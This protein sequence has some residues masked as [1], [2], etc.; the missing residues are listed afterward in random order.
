M[1]RKLIISFVF[2]MFSTVVQ[3]GPMAG[4]QITFAWDEHT[5]ERVEGFRLYYGKISRF[6]QSVLEA[7]SDRFALFC[8]KDQIPELYTAEQYDSCVET[9]VN[10][11]P[12][13]KACD[14]DYY[15][16]DTVVPII[17][18]EKTEYTLKNLPDG[19]YY[20]TLTAYFGKLESKFSN[21]LKHEIDAK[22]PGAVIGVSSRLT[23]KSE[24]KVT[25]ERI[26]VQP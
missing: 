9:W 5:D 2:L 16:Y 25:V 12:D 10:Y 26:E 11:C 19:K 21:E 13:D 6:D 22:A 23:D 15:S 8:K 24:W 20:F 4:G 3:A 18:G 17:G 1:K 14:P 7:L